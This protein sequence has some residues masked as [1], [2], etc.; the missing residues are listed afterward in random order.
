MVGSQKHEGCMGGESVKKSRTRGQ[1]RC[2]GFPG[3]GC[4]VVRADGGAELAICHGATHDVDHPVDRCSRL[5]EQ[6]RAFSKVLAERPS[7]PELKKQAASTCVLSQPKVNRPSPAAQASAKA[8]AL[9]SVAQAFSL[10]E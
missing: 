2:I 7:A 1:L 9:Q 10:T 4:R 3:L 8:S 6:S 5:A